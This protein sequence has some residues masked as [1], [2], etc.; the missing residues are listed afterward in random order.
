MRE[1][2]E[3]KIKLYK[4]LKVAIPMIFKSSPLL[5]CLFVLVA[6]LHGISW[7]V[8]VFLTQMFYNSV[9][10]AIRGGLGFKV[11]V[12][13]LILLGIVMIL[14]QIINGVHSFVYI[15]FNQKSRGYMMQI[16]HKKIAKISPI[17]YEDSSVM[18]EIN[19]AEKGTENIFDLVF[20]IIM[21]FTFFLPY[22][23]FMAIWLYTLKPILAITIIISSI[24]FFITKIS[25]IKIYVELEDESANER[26][27]FEYYEQSICSREYFKE[28]RILGVYDFF[29]KLYLH[30]L[31]KLNIMRWKVEKKAFTRDL[32]GKIISLL[33][34]LAVLY[35]F[36]D[37]FLKGDITAGA[38]AALFPAIGKMQNM[39][40]DFINNFSSISENSGT[41]NNLLNFLDMQECD[42]SLINDN[43]D[44]TIVLSHVSF[45]YPGADYD[46]LKDISLSIKMVKQLLS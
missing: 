46:S 44:G 29:S 39:I 21:T 40:T 11:I 22:I 4:L 41:I 9:S 35:L 27:I 33:G 38:F 8:N 26:R 23:L 45:I 6:I 42:G 14:S 2:N 20:S 15:P 13:T 17:A 1:Q 37:A 30:S 19:K 16:I 3:K 7:G 34:Y 43:L 28:T 32:V 12:P 31:Y 5:F 18:D 10:D 24:P 36:V 25:Q